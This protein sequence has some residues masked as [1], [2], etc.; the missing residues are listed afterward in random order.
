[1]HTMPLE[2]M[3]AS[4]EAAHSLSN[5]HHTLFSTCSAHLLNPALHISIRLLFTLTSVRTWDVPGTLTKLCRVA[6]FCR[7]RLVTGGGGAT[8]KPTCRRRGG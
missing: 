7:V 8:F 5:T 3:R 6:M 4:K 1:M 2:R